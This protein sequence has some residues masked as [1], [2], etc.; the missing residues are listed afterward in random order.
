[1]SFKSLTEDQQR[2]FARLCVER[3]KGFETWTKKRR[4]LAGKDVLIVADRPGPKA[5]QTDDFHQT[6]FY[7]KIHS[8][9]FLNAQFILNG[10]TEDRLAWVNS[11]TWDGNPTEPD[12]LTAV[13][14]THILA[15]GG[16]ADKWLRKNGVT[17]FQRFD[18]PQF[19][20]RFKSTE[21]YP[22]IE[23]LTSLT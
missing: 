9:G 2:A 13:S 3:R 11:A 20:K 5:P 10:I 22:L 21:P 1:M 17:K 23:F 14:W 6:P 15:L 12:I 18:H 16:N 7:A 19:H 8:G 4:V